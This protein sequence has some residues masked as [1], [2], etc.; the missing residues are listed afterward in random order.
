MCWRKKF[1]A[2]RKGQGFKCLQVERVEYA[3]GRASVRNA[4]ALEPTFT[5]IP[6]I[7]LVKTARDRVSARTAG[8][9]V[10]Q[11][12]LLNALE[13]Y[14]QSESFLNRKIGRKRARIR[15]VEFDS[16][17]GLYYYRA[18]YYD[19]RIGRFLSEDALRFVTG[20]NFYPYTN[21]NPANLTDPLGLCSI[22]LR[23]SSTMIGV[24]RHAYIL[25]QSATPGCSHFLSNG[26]K[27]TL[28]SSW[29]RFWLRLSARASQCASGGPKGSAA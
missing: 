27:P 17:T 12:S 28:S 13:S 7:Q 23:F 20:S 1:D 5:S 29:A 9:S 22:S 10:T 3:E 18:R 24:G 6:V 14:S 4:S 25:T 8:E 2:A 26:S 11:I 21:N 19:S 15:Q 16:E